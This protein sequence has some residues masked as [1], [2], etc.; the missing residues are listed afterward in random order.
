VKTPLSRLLLT[1]LSAGIW[2]MIGYTAYLAF[3][4]DNGFRVTESATWNAQGKPQF[5][6][7]A[8]DSFVA[9]RAF[10]L[11]RVTPGD[12]TTEIHSADERM[13]INVSRGRVGQVPTGCTTRNVLTP[14]PKDL[15][16]GKY[17]LRAFLMHELNPL[18]SLRRE[19]PPVEFEIIP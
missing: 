12:Y 9:H 14:I 2:L 4:D 11:D 5:T 10:C 19:L 17:R 13:V 15:P 1:V 7:R 18:R 8:G 6:F 16:P 3:V